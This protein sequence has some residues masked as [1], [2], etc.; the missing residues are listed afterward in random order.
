MKTAIFSYSFTGNNEKLA[1]SV[2]RE[3]LV[4]QIKITE[5]TERTV[6]K[7][8]ADAIFNRVP[9]VLPSPGKLLDYDMIL[10]FGPV[11]IGQVAFPLRAYLQYLRKNPKDYAFI[12]LS[13]GP[14]GPNPKLESELISRTAKNPIALINLYIAGLLP[15]EP[16]PTPKDIDSYKLKEE[17]I[18]NL[19]Q[20]VLGKLSGSITE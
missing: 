9:Q 14:N 16:K 15:S 20:T 4:E 17:D 6:G 3:L 13:G 8:T 5:P 10:F 12:S 18:I 7:I 11:W 2:A 1:Q 19:T